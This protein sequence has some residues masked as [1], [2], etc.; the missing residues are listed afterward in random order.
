MQVIGLLL[1]RKSNKEFHQKKTLI[2]KVL[3]GITDITE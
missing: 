1:K 2:K 3:T